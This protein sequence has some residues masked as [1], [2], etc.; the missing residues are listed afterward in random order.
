MG[1][2]HSGDLGG[3]G[4][5]GRLEELASQGQ[6]LAQRGRDYAAVLLRLREDVWIEGHLSL[7][8]SNDGLR[9]RP[10]DLLERQTEHLLRLIDA[11]VQVGP[12][13]YA[14]RSIAVNK[15]SVMFIHELGDLVQEDAARGEPSAS[16]Q[17]SP[18]RA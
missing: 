6:A 17:V 13:T 4:L 14:V 15:D 10:F 12:E 3:R 1:S 18:R 9:I 2:A 8:P 16:R 5:S 7:P 11:R